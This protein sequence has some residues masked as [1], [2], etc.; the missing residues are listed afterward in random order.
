MD[1]TVGRCSQCGGNVTVPS[2]WLGI[3]PPVPTCHSC[4][5]QAVSRL[6]IIETE[7]V[8]EANSVGYLA[9]FDKWTNNT[10]SKLDKIY[11]LKENS[12]P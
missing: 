4:G 1:K 10:R 11:N 9:E 7:P 2:E 6:P 8:A 5:A 12:K 3:H